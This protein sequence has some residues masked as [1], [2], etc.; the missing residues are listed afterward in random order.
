MFRYQ[1]FCTGCD[2]ATRQSEPQV[3]ERA[4]CVKPRNLKGEKIMSGKKRMS[5]KEFAR[6]DTEIKTILQDA[7]EQLPAKKLP[8]RSRNKGIHRQE[9]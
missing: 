5:P 9:N 7:L 1:R 8:S 3:S 6:L 2:R 4:A